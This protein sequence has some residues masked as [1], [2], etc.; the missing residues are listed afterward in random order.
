M[1]VNHSPIY[2]WFG[3]SESGVNRNSKATAEESSAGPFKR[4]CDRC[5]KEVSTAQPI[6]STVFYCSIECAD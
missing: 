4:K 3:M 1:S 6:I 5:G 2:R